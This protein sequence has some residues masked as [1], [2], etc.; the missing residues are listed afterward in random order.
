M[1]A[2]LDVA[3]GESQTVTITKDNFEELQNLC[4]ELD[5]Q[6][7]NR[8]LR[9]FERLK[10]DK[11]VLFE[12][13]LDE[14][15]KRLEEFGDQFW[16]ATVSL[17]EENEFS[18]SQLKEQIREHE[19]LF[20]EVERRLSELESEKT[21]SEESRE[22][23]SRQ[24]QSLERKFDDLARV[25]E[26]RNVEASW[27]TEQALRECAKQ[28]DFEE[29]ARDLAQLK[30]NEKKTATK[31][32]ATPAKPAAPALGKRRH[33][34]YNSS[35]KLDGVIAHLTLECGGNVHDNKIVNVTASSVYS[36]S[37]HPKNAVDLGT[38]SVYG[39]NDKK[40]TW[41]CYDFKERRVIPTSYS[42]MSYKKRPGGHH[43]KSWVIEVSNDGSSWT[44]IDRRDNNNDLNHRYAIANFKI[45]PVPS[46][47]FR[48]FR[49]RQT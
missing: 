9:V 32:P 27:K 34:F 44:E 40:D 4:D 25:C 19:R 13:R 12:E 28:R 2:V 23:V 6:G 30:E 35:K 39:S 10:P 22:S 36:G 29:L 8:E 7:L 5:F 17:K 16:D 21:K 15:E 26:E 3:D 48:F 43:L 1:N 24:V 18:L 33:L 14:Y 31:S 47:C 49:L 38:N 11:F 46:D 37:Y 42:V 45:F 20:Q 41:I